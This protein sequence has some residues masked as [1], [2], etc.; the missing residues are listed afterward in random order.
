MSGGGASTTDGG[1]DTN[2][3]CWTYGGGV[4]T[5]GRGICVKESAGCTKRLFVRMSPR[6]DD[7]SRKIN[8]EDWRGCRVRIIGAHDVCACYLRINRCGSWVRRRRAYMGARMLGLKKEEDTCAGC[9]KRLR[10]CV[11]C[12]RVWCACEMSAYVCTVYLDAYQNGVDHL[13]S[14]R[15]RS[16]LARW[17]NT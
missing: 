6:T 10:V 15:R 12:V 2:G 9:N 16:H 3:G 7:S 14:E 13:P 1:M 11:S 5:K 17:I 4:G 8:A